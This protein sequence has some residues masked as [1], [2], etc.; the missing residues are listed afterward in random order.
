[1]NP[2]SKQIENYIE[3]HIEVYLERLRR[4]CAQPSISAQNRGLEEMAELCVEML[5]DIDVDAE[6]VRANGPPVVLGR[7]VGDGQRSLLFYNHYDVQPVDPLDEWETAPFEAVIRDGKFYARGAADNKGAIV[8]RI[9]ALEAYLAHHEHLPVDIL[10]VIEGEEE[11]GSPHLD[12]FVDRHADT[13]RQVYACVWEAG[14]KDARGRYEIS[15]GCKG[16][17]YVTLRARGADTDLHSALAAIVA[18]P[19]WRLSWAL[20]ALKGSDG[21]VQ[22]PGFYDSVQPITPAQREALAAWD[23]PESETRDLYGIDGFLGDLSGERLKEALIFSPTCNIAGFHAGYGGPGSK[24]VLPREATAKLDF[25]LVPDQSPEEIV[26]QLRA[27]LDAQGFSDVE[28]VASDGEHPVSGDPEHPFTQSA[29]RAAERVYG[30]TPA[31]LP[32]MSGTGPVHVLCGQFGVPIATAGVGYSGSR[33]HGPN[34]HIHV[35]D[36][37][38]GIKYIVALLDEFAA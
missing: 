10:W 2:K 18:N 6:L 19:V 34:E 32:M 9:C 20:N 1:M 12:Q 16:L 11:V 27:Y 36:F 14:G 37:I 3:A 4:A 7:V 35:A 13:L 21:R 23:Y 8:S 28:I 24:T 33:A 5:K 26:A 30:H 31:V 25:R 15:L 22:I 29:V 38:E 17:L